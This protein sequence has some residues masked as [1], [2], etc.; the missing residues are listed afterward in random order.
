MG[1]NSIHLN[2]KSFVEGYN[3]TNDTIFKYQILD[4]VT[5]ARTTLTSIS[6]DT[7]R[8]I[9][10]IDGNA[11]ISVDDTLVIRDKDYCVVEIGDVPNTLASKKR[12][13]YDNVKGS[14]VVSLE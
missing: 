14:M 5:A 1:F 13:D 7:S 6:L 8:M 2:G 9:I 4:R 12:A 11:S 10:Q 3:K